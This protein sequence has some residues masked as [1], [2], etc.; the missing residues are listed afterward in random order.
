MSA[1]NQPDGKGMDMS[2]GTHPTVGPMIGDI[3]KEEASFLSN[4]AFRLGVAQD[5]IE[6][7]INE[8][9]LDVHRLRPQGEVE[10]LL[11]DWRPTTENVSK[12]RSALLAI[13][14]TYLKFKCRNYHRQR[15]RAAGKTSLED[16]SIRR[17]LPFFEDGGVR[18]FLLD[19]GLLNNLDAERLEQG[20]PTEVEKFFGLL[21]FKARLNEQER[22]FVLF[23]VAN[24]DARDQDFDPDFKPYQITRIKQ[25]AFRKIG[26]FLAT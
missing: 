12:L 6:D 10:T 18:R 11:N 16:E 14:I 25:S 7:V 1:V 19:L 2:L 24:P 8:A 20:D 9:Y 26:G 23:R 15:S 21:A 13:F 5:D 4:L 22:A 3:L 17:L